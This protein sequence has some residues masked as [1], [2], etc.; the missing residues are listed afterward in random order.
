M[1]V[2]V[3]AA[4]LER[5]LTVIGK[6]EAMTQALRLQARC[7]QADTAML[8]RTLDALT[9]AELND[10]PASLAARERQDVIDAM[11]AAHGSQIRAADHLGITPRVLCY[12][13]QKFGLPRGRGDAAKA[14]WAA[15]R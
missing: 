4:L 7:A 8:V 12:K 1:S 9:A 15:W 6:Y 3:E 11:V 13:L 5:A 14:Q 10:R 2:Y